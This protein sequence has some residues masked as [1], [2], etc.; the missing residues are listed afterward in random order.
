MTR[1]LKRDIICCPSLSCG[2]SVADLSDEVPDLPNT[3]RMYNRRQSSYQSVAQT[4][5]LQPHVGWERR[6]STY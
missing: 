6:K 3:D 1:R 4:D 2:L 5:A